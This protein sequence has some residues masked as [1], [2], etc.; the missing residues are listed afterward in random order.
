[1]KYNFPHISFLLFF[2]FP[3]MNIFAM[4]FQFL[5]QEP[6]VPMTHYL[7]AYFTG[8][9]TTGQQVCFAVSNNGLDWE[10]LNAGRPVINSDTISISGGV[11]D[12]HILRGDDGWFRMVVTDMDWQQGKWSNHGIVMLRSR[13]LINWEHHPVDFHVRYA[14]L[15]YGE[16]NA[17]WAPQT[18]FDPTVGKYLVYFSLHSPKG[19]PYEKDAVFY[20]YANDE[21]SDLEDIP[22]RLF[23][24]PDPTIDTDIVQTADGIYHIFFNTWGKNGLQRRQFTGQN[25]HQPELWHLLPGRMQPNAIA[26]EGSTA[27]P[28]I[29]SDEWILCYD[30][31]L[32]SIFQFC[33]TN[34]LEHFTLERETQTTGSFTPRHGSVIHISQEEFELI[35]NSPS[36]N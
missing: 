6:S 4:S 9:E 19:G 15:L 35:S 5:L 14:G 22:Q 2:S 17:V 12:P 29:D 28:L 8:N 31:H 25:L 10:P 26:S 7:F 23:T 1:M 30:C 27:F 36:R 33:R 34:D 18:I 24:Y 13:D 3:W 21:F 32:D 11:R 16:I 20:C